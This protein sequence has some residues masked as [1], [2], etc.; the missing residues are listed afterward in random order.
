MKLPL[1]LLS[2]ATAQE[3]GEPAAVA[4]GSV[5]RNGNKA[6]NTCNVG[7]CFNGE[8]TRTINTSCEN[9][10][11]NELDSE[12]VPCDECSLPSVGFNMEAKFITG[13]MDAEISCLEGVIEPGTD[14]TTKTISCIEGGKWNSD[15]PTCSMPPIINCE[16]EYMEAVIDKNMLRAKNWDGTA[17]NIFLSGPGSSLMGL[18]DVDPNCFSVTDDAGNYVLRIN[19]P[20]MNQCGTQSDIIGDD[21]EF[22]NV[23]KW[24]Y[25][26][27]SMH[28][29]KEANVLDFRC[30]YRGVFMAGLPHKVKLA[31]NTKT[32][33][34]D[35]GDDF[36][37]SMSVYDQEDF[38]GLVDNIPILHRGKRYFVDLHLH[39]SDKGTPYLRHCYGSNNY[40]SEEELKQKYQMQTASSAVRNMIV[41]GCPA[42]M[43]LVKLENAPNTYQS[44]FSFMFPKLGRGIADLQ[45]VYLHCEIELMSKGFAPTCDDRLFDQAL[46]R[47]FNSG[48]VAGIGQRAGMRPGGVQ[49][50]KM[51]DLPWMKNSNICADQGR[52]RRS[53][54][55]NMS[56]GFGPLVVPEKEE[57]AG[58][59]SERP[60]A[61]QLVDV[62]G[63][64]SQI[65]ASDKEPVD[66]EIEEIEIVE[67]VVDDGLNLTEGFRKRRKVL[68][69]SCMAVGCFLLFLLSLAV[70]S[71][72]SC[73]KSTRKSKKISTNVLSSQIQ[74]ELSKASNI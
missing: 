40:V 11:W 46:K 64:D 37:V 10:S 65:F 24:R 17:S 6:A 9:G 66:I 35:N 26:G 22:S 47:N 21:Y 53:V 49:G 27:D 57:V 7:F 59:N 74:R 32:Y 15:I 42:P 25:E 36:T 45:F 68:I 71:R 62:V 2:A 39:N 70:S 30:V 73:G 52:K 55:S 20:F 72:I 44:R 8:R 16:D 13:S 56:L 19:A 28:V 23:V 1:I 63:E 43:T 67:V 50:K 51:C 69:I 38:S 33:T 41:N 54:Q 3:C 12:C 58:E 34:D 5:V 60:T 31:I 48:P 29:V 4:N 61:S 18:D 14:K